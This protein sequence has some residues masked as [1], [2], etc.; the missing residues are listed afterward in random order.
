M[1]AWVRFLELDSWC[2]SKS[3]GEDRPAESVGEDIVEEVVQFADDSNAV[4]G[5]AGQRDHGFEGDLPFVGLIDDAGLE[6]SRRRLA[7]GGAVVDRRLE[8]ELCDRDQM[9]E[10]V[11]VNLG[12]VRVEV[13]QTVLEREAPVERADIGTSVRPVLPG[14]SRAELRRDRERTE[15]L[16]ALRQ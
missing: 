11:V 7:G 12:D 1:C 13:G 9:L 8:R 14:R 4:A 6:I 5:R 3:V 10:E 16:E 15:Q 2:D